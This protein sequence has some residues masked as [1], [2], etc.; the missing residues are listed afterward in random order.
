MLVP[1]LIWQNKNGFVYLN[2]KLYTSSTIN[3]GKPL[4]KEV[5]WHTGCQWNDSDKISLFTLKN[6]KGQE[7]NTFSKITVIQLFSPYKKLPQS[8]EAHLTEL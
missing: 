3:S 6:I 7:N 2:R 1:E 4:D 5:R 8:Q